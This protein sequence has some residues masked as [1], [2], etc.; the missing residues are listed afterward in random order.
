M[1]GLGTQDSLGEARE[2]VSRYGTT[3]PMLYDSSSASWRALGVVQQPAALLL[4]REGAAVKRWSGEFDE[5]E[6]LRLSGRG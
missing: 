6:V 5:A 3:F 4:S 1:I 2:F